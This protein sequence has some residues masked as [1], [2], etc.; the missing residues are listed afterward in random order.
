[1]GL[2]TSLVITN[3]GNVYNWGLNSHGQ[4]GINN[5]TNTKDIKTQP[6]LNLSQ[7]ERIVDASVGGFQTVLFTNTG[8]LF[9]YGINTHNSLLANITGNPDIL[10]PL[11]ITN[12]F[13]NQITK[14]SLSVEHYGTNPTN[15]FLDTN[16]NLFSVGSIQY[17]LGNG[18]EVTLNKLHNITNNMDLSKGEYIKDVEAGDTVVSVL[19]SQ[20]RILTWGSDL[21]GSLGSGKLAPNRD[22][23]LE[24]YGN[25]T[26]N[27]DTIFYPTSKEVD[28]INQTKPGMIFDGWYQNFDPIKGLYTNKVDS[29]NSITS[30]IK[31]YAKWRKEI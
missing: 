8:R 7:D 18:K 28:L 19:T 29:I 11:D 26:K 2:D 22:L 21:Y 5:R 10:V 27:I 6:I 3:K 31:L 30:N 4:L 25:K 24:I 13:T 1:M 17:N 9:V 12:R 16:N 20:G 23:P 14:V 15:F